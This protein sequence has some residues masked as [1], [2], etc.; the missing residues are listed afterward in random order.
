MNVNWNS[1][2]REWNV[3][4][5]LVTNPNE[6]N[7]GNQVVSKLSS[8]NPVFLKGG[9]VCFNPPTEHSAYFIKSFRENDISFVV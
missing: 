1:T 7:A 8:F 6:W 4:A 2:N 3:E 5:N 9:V